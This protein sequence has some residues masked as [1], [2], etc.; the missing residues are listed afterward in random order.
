MKTKREQELEALARF[1]AAGKV[2]KLAP[3]RVADPDEGY[4][5]APLT[6]TL[7]EIQRGAQRAG[8]LPVKRS[9]S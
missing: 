3:M 4:A 7:G 6:Y 1:A 8:L 5:P 9:R 2:K